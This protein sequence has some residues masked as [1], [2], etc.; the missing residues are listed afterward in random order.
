MTTE[1]QQRTIQLGPTTITA[2]V[3]VTT[4]WP[5]LPV[6]DAIWN[7]VRAAYPSSFYNA[8]TLLGRVHCY[9][10]Q[11]ASRTILVDTG[12]GKA[13]PPTPALS[14]QQLEAQLSLM[15]IDATA[16]DTVFLTHLHVDHVGLNTHYV[17]DKLQARFPNARYLAHKAEQ[18]LIEFMQT[19]T[20]ERAGY[21]QDQVLWLNEQGYLDFFEADFELTEG[22]TTW[23]T[24]GH[25]P[26]HTGL[27][28]DHGTGER[29][30]IAGDIFFNPIQMFHP[31]FA[32][33]LDVD[34]EQAHATRL[35][36]LQQV[37]DGKTLVAACHFPTPSFG[38]VVPDGDAYR[39]QPIAE[40]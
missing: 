40:D 33:G 14:S 29:V 25:S 36:V 38:Y 28:I 19:H 12:L 24:P 10:I 6:S 31:S 2:I 11:Q 16:I 3:D 34:K 37:S 22:I 20:P 39:W 30:L 4:P 13:P 32:T 5:M 15:G 9:L 7:K 8:E 1:L 21:L 35:A 26:G 27:L 18:G 17:D 23:F